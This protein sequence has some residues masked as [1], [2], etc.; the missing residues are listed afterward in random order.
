MAFQIR[1]VATSRLVN[2]FTASTP[3]RVFQ[4][5]TRRAAGHFAASAANSCEL[6]KASI[7]SRFSSI[8]CEESK[9]VMSLLL[10]IVNVVIGSF[11]WVFTQYDDIH[12]S[13]G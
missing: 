11:L 1:A 12:G 9:T 2:R 13:A 10:S 5:S 7:P 4:I 8:F 3:G 6:V